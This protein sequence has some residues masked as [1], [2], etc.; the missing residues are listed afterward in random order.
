[1]KSWN[2]RIRFRSSFQEIRFPG[3]LGI[4][5]SRAIPDSHFPENV[6]TSLSGNF[7]N[8]VSRKASGICFPRVF[9]KYVSVRDARL[10]SSEIREIWELCCSENFGNQLVVTPTPFPWKSGNSSSRDIPKF[11]DTWKRI[12]IHPQDDPKEI[13]R[14]IYKELSY[15]THNITRKRFFFLIFYFYNCQ[16]ESTPGNLFSPKLNVYKIFTKYVLKVRHC[17]RCP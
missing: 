5:V 6:R 16:R 11:R 8:F 9:R 10:I 3:N 7:G 17:Q 13:Q 4:P 12:K 2:T 1:M 15:D 14:E